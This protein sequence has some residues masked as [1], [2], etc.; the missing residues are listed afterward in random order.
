MCQPTRIRVDGRLDEAIWR[1]VPAITDFVQREPGEGAPPTDRM[2][3]RFAY[4]DD[5]LYIGARMYS[6]API[7][8]PLGRRDEGDQ[9]E[10]L[11]VSLDT[12]LNRAPSPRSASRRPVSGSTSPTRRITTGPATRGSIR[13][14][15]RAPRL[16]VPDGARSCGYRS[17]SCASPIWKR[18]SGG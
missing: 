6:S 11:I 13:C 4:D 17:R 9:A 3:I 12:Y 18:R 2:E 16:M 7:Q 5:A 14:G 10:H 15:R 1:D 8:S